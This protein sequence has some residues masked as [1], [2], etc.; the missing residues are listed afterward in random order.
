MSYSLN[1]QQEGR[2][3]L[4]S[5]S[6]MLGGRTYRTN[7][8]QINILRPGTTDKLDLE[9]TL[10]EQR[11]Y[12]GQPV[13]LTVRFYISTDIG[14]FQFNIPALN[15]NAFYVEDPDVSNQQV[16]QFRLS[17]GMSVFVN[18]TR[19]VHNGKDSILLS[20]SKVSDLLLQR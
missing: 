5:V 3:Q 1:A 10:F 18:Q 14:D 7:P 11:C 12:V 6:V 4:P 13:I 2:I 8:V 9:V 15:S 20:F 16:K 17:M 19:V